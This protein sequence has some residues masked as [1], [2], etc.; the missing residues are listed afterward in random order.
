MPQFKVNSA[1]PSHPRHF[2]SDDL[3]LSSVRV[4]TLDTR[5]EFSELYQLSGCTVIP[6]AYKF[7][8]VRFVHLVQLLALPFS[9][10]H[11]YSILSSGVC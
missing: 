9:C 2:L 3:V 7:L 10:H 4:K 6:T 1:G 5:K 8:C 11:R